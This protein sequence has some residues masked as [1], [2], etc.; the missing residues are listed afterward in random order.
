MD[1]SVYHCSDLE[2]KRTFRFFLRHIPLNGLGDHQL[3]GIRYHYFSLILIRISNGGLG[4]LVHSYTCC[5]SVGLAVVAYLIAY[6]C[7]LIAV[8]VRDGLSH[9]IASGFQLI[10][11]Q[12]P[13][14]VCIGELAQA[15]GCFL[16]G[17]TAVCLYII[18][19]TIYF[20]GDGKLKSTFCFFLGH[21]TL[22]GLGDHQLAGIRYYHFLFILICVC[23]CCGPVLCY[24]RACGPSIDSAVVV[25]RIAHACQLIAVDVCDRLSHTIASGFQLVQFQCPLVIIVGKLAQTDGCLFSGQIAVCLYV[26]GDTAYFLSDRE[27][28]R[29]FC[30]FLGHITFDGLGDH[31]LAGIRY[32]ILVYVCISNCSLAVRTYRNNC[33]LLVDLSAHTIYRIVHTYKIITRNICYCLCY[34]VLASLQLIQLQNVLSVN[35]SKLA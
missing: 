1:L 7:Q 14:V 27:L 2:L 24:L 5:F 30:L 4:I 12:C 8:D 32:K 21:I 35:I 9:I 19:I 31:Q 17:Q 16:G 22:D 33:G 28:K 26:I 6:T 20:C 25:Y 29:S 34:A 3:A 23:N 15:D 10:Q 18:C 11:L 13:L